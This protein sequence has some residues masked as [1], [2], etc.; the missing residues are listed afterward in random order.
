[1]IHPDIL[2][3]LNKGAKSLGI[4]NSEFL[5]RYGSRV[6]TI[7]ETVAF[8]IFERAYKG[9]Y[10]PTEEEIKVTMALCRFIADTNAKLV[11][12]VN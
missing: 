11:P 6:D 1:M 7:S 9:Q 5:Q 12:D 4:S 2:V 10:D 8:R 3:A